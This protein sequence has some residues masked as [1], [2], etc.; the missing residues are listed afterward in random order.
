MW[1]TFKWSKFKCLHPYMCMVCVCKSCLHSVHIYTNLICCARL[2]VW[3]SALNNQ[4]YSCKRHCTEQTAEIYKVIWSHLAEISH[5]SSYQSSVTKENY[6]Q[7]TEFNS[8]K[9]NNQKRVQGWPKQGIL[10]G[11]SKWNKSH[12]C[13]DSYFEKTTTTLNGN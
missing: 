1:S 7:H 9:A 13:K 2:S 6:S 4:F 10:E 5:F 3:Y 8:W 11:S 12:G